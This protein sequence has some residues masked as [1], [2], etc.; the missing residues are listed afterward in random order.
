MSERACLSARYFVP[1]VHTSVIG[2][3][4]GPTHIKH[5]RP[6]PQSLR[7]VGEKDV[8]ESWAREDARTGGF[9]R[10]EKDT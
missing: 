1:S 9:R 3:A 4:P 6:S 2:D 5:P 8:V 7:I 10:S